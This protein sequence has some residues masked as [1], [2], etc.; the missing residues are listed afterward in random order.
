[1]SATQEHDPAKETPGASDVDA[2]I[3]EEAQR[4]ALLDELQA[5]LDGAV[6]ALGGLLQLLEASE[7]GAALSAAQLRA[8]L[9]PSVDH[10][11]QAQGCARLL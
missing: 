7:P 9:A 6:L 2:C 1:M 3:D 10:L 4:A 8:L 11:T 5:W